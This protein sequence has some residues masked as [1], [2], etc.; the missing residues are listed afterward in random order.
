[1]EDNSH[2]ANN[3]GGEEVEKG[4]EKDMFEEEEIHV[5]HARR[6]HNEVSYVNSYLGN[7]TYGWNSDHM[8]HECSFCIFFSPNNDCYTM[9]WN[10][11]L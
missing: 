8:V 7:D 2:N 10:I 4:Q 5:K 9:G 6:H 1:M 11:P 3:L